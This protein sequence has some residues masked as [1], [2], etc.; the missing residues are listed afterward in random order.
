MVLDSKQIIRI[1]IFSLAGAPIYVCPEQHL[2][3][4]TCWER[5]RERGCVLCRAPYPKTPRRDRVLEKVAE[6]LHQLRL[7]CHSLMNGED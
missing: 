2:V 7:K 5:V 6:D 3:C 4:S 1:V